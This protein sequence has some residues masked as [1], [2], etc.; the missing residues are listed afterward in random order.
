VL[1]LSL[2]DALNQRDAW[3]TETKYSHASYENTT[4][5]PRLLLINR[6]TSAQPVMMAL[7]FP[8]V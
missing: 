8:A 3:S 6:V 1:N 7:V 5:S 4:M 2:T